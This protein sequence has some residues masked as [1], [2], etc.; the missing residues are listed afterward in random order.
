MTGRATGTRSSDGLG[1]ARPA[2]RF[3]HPD[4]L[5]VTSW[6]GRWLLMHVNGSTPH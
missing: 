3:P 6:D 5:V 2:V 4:V 1:S